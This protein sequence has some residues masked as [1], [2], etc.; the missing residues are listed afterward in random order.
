VPAFTLLS[1]AGT[2]IHRIRIYCKII[3]PCKLAQ[4]GNLLTCIR[5]VMGSNLGRDTDYSETFHGFPESL[6]GNSRAV[7]LKRS[8]IGLFLYH[9]QTV[10]YLLISYYSM[11]YR[12]L[13]ATLGA[14]VAQ[15]V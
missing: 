5:D 10:I 7:L 12:Q 14:G 2:Q 11:L 15:S 6:H 4:V 8:R 9:Y 3:W 1:Q 13:L